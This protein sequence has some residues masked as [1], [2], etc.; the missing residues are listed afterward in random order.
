MKGCIRF[1]ILEACCKA[2]DVAFVTF[3]LLVF[4]MSL[5]TDLISKPEQGAII[6]GVLNTLQNLL[7][8]GELLAL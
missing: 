7:T 5:T 1:R 3:T 8:G 6:V 4:R 2:G